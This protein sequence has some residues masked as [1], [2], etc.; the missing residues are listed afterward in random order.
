MAEGLL[1]HWAKADHWD[2]EAKSAGLAAFGGLPAATEA[3][4]A[5]KEKGVDISAHQSQP[6]SKELVLES[7]LIV[8]MTVK[9]KESILRKMPDLENKVKVLAELAGEGL[10]DIEDPVGL[11]LEEYRKVL[12]QI[13]GY[14][15]KSKSVFNQ[16]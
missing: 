11:P 16:S 1:N 3:I 13:E 10:V 6:L 12:G 5:C 8:T 2:V 4:E 14:L 9:H 7:D 15:E